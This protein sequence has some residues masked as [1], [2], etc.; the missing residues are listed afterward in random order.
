LRSR[1]CRSS[2]FLRRSLSSRKCTV[3]SRLRRDSC[4]AQPR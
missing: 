3:T 2:G 1:Y 4:A